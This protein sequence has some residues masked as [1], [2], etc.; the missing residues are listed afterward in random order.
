MDEVTSETWARLHLRPHHEPGEDTS[1]AVPDV[2]ATASRPPLPVP[3]QLLGFHGTLSA[4][5]T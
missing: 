1:T 3:S 2:V 4:W 5:D